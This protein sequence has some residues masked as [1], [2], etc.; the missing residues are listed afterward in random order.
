MTLN[1]Y[2]SERAITTKITVNHQRLMLM[3]VYF[4]HLVYADHHIE[5]MYKTIQ[6]H[7]NSRKKNIQI[8]GGDFNADLGTGYGV[9]RVSVG[10]H[11]LKEENKE[12]TG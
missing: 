11:T 1:K 4:L 9:E 8:V 6:K 3:S 12:E 5:I 2:I 10:Q 7:T